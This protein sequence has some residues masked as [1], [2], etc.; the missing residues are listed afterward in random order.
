MNKEG[1][2]SPVSRGKLS[3]FQPDFHY[4]EIAPKD[5]A[6][7]NYW[8]REKDKLVFVICEEI[9]RQLHTYTCVSIS[10]NLI[11]FMRT[12][13]FHSI[14]QNSFKNNSNYTSGLLKL[15]FT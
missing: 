11:S 8:S 10:G 7:E 4:T 1:Q 3:A 12:I 6:N 14:F 15:D 9:K 2:A 13:H 5:E